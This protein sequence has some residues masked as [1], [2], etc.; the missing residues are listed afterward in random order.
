MYVEKINQDKVKISACCVNT[1]GSETDSIDFD[2]DLYLQSQR[3]LVREHKQVPGCNRCDNNPTQFSLRDSAIRNFLQFTPVDPTQP[4]LTKLD[5][6]V[7]PICNARCIQCSS[8]FSSAWAA[9]DAAHGKIIDVRT[10]NSTRHNSVSESIDVSQLTSLYF[11]GGEPMLS[12]EP[13]EFLR[14]IDQLGNIAKLNL[15]FNTNGSIRP[16]AEF[17]ELAARCNSVVVN[18]SLDGTGL[19]F[20]YIRNLLSWEIVEQNICWWNDQKIPN[21][22]FNIAFV[23]GIY[24]IDIV[25]DTYNWHKDMAQ[26]HKQI[27]G[28]VIQPCY[29]DLALDYSSAKL[30]QVWAEKYTGDDYI[31]STI[32]S[33]LEKSPDAKDDKHWQRHLE[34]IDSRRKLDWTT[35]LP[36]LH[37]AWKN[38][39]SL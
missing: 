35:C 19:T 16:A 10:T 34:M 11:N 32:R 22:E 8:H 27:K 17:I 31:H 4:I 36:K 6:N 24:N 7:D 39:Q 18:F 23:L 29:G 13:L 28:F 25:E 5:W 20:E 14:R 37:K 9:E 21:I 2:H 30:K 38:S 26:T 15:S 33:M 1:L 12:K 3:Q